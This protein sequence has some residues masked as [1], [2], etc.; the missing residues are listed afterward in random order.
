MVELGSRIDQEAEPFATEADAQDFMD[1]NCLLMDENE[2]RESLIDTFASW[3]L[4]GFK[5]S[6]LDI[7][8]G[9]KYIAG[10]MTP[11]DIIDYFRSLYGSADSDTSADENHSDIGYRVL[12][13]LPND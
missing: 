10:E 7:E 9:R 13:P 3:S 1:K 11:E 4:D 5:P 12:G 2:R 6:A 8:L